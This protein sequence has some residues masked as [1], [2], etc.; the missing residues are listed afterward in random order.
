MGDEIRGARPES[1]T[2]AEVDD[3]EPLIDGAYHAY[4]RDTTIYLHN[5]LPLTKY[6]RQYVAV[7]NAKGEKEAW[8]NFFCADFN[9]DWRHA[10]MIVDDGE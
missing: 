9:I 10:P 3:L 4:T 5:L 1:L 6:R 2:A 7:R 8:V